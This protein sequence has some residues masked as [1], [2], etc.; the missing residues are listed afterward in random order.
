MVMSQELEE[1]R[2]T[3]CVT[4]AH[5]MKE[6]TLSPLRS[7]GPGIER[8]DFEIYA[9]FS[10]SSDFHS[11]PPQNLFSSS[12]AS[13]TTATM[14]RN[15]CSAQSCLMHLSMDRNKVDIPNERSFEFPYLL[16]QGTK[17]VLRLLG[18]FTVLLND[19]Q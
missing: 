8:Q 15:S 13:N 3:R 2:P 17:K 12:E 16:L 18:E 4:M 14:N 5:K 19:R 7:N 9:W 1:R 10:T 6:R 11:L